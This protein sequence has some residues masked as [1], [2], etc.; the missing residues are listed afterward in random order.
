MNDGNSP[1]NGKLRD[2][3]TTGGTAKLVRLGNAI[4]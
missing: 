1:F 2:K 4:E 3:R